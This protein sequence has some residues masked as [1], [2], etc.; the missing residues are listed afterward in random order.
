[1]YT[2]NLELLEDIVFGMC[3]AH[4]EICPHKYEW[5]LDREKEGYRERHYEC[6]LC[7]DKKTRKIPITFSERKEK[8][9][10]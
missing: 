6:S 9:G 2:R 7:G 8:T 10:D 4:P 3:R 5:V 1:M